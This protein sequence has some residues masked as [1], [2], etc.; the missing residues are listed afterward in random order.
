MTG[1]PTGVHGIVS[2]ET[3]EINI[4]KITTKEVPVVVKADASSIG[5]GYQVGEGVASPK[6]HCNGES[7]NIHRETSRIK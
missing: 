1:L 2:P 6:G 4:E 3:V 7:S 5:N